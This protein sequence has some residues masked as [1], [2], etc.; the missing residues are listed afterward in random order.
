MSLKEWIFVLELLSKWC[1]D[2]KHIC[3]HIY[4]CVCSRVNLFQVVVVWLALKN[5]GTCGFVLTENV[6]AL[7]HCVREMAVK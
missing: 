6:I 7:A 4:L 1:K 2:V 5:F 3:M